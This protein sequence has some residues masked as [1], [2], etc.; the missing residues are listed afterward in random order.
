MLSILI[1]LIGSIEFGINTGGDYPIDLIEEFLDGG[2]FTSVF[3]HSVSGVLNPYHGMYLWSVSDERIGSLSNL[4]NN[5]TP[6]KIY[7]EAGYTPRWMSGWNTTTGMINHIPETIDW[8]ADLVS[9]VVNRYKTGGVLGLSNGITGIGLWNEPD[10]C[11][12]MGGIGDPPDVFLG[13]IKYGES[14][15]LAATAASEADPNIEVVTGGFLSPAHTELGYDWEMN[16]EARLQPVFTHEY[17]YWWQQGDVVPFAIAWATMPSSLHWHPYFEHTK[18]P[19][20]WVYREWYDPLVLDQGDPMYSTRP[21]ELPELLNDL[22]L[23]QSFPPFD[24]TEISQFAMEYCPTF[25]YNDYPLYPSSEQIYTKWR[26]NYFLTVNLMLLQSNHMDMI[27]PYPASADKWWVPTE[28]SWYNVNY[29]GSGLEYWADYGYRHQS[30]L[31]GGLTCMNFDDSR[32]VPQGKIC[33]WKYSSGSSQSEEVLAL[34][35]TR[36]ILLSNFDYNQNHT[37]RLPLPPGVVDV[38]QTNLRGEPVI[39]P[40]IIGNGSV[41][42]QVNGYIS[43]LEYIYTNQQES[44]HPIESVQPIWSRAGNSITVTVPSTFNR[45]F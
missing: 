36:E 44:A 12:H 33:I 7:L 17:P 1:F 31:L 2:N 13:M 30:S 18:E 41:T 27:A 11:G 28:N 19:M 38:Q 24:W 4:T 26:A 20:G 40:V 21:E 39:T 15:A 42:V 6:V 3:E 34:R 16:T 43:Y 8:Y 35:T 5:G 14:A 37:V 9:A 25:T 45:Q 10:G 32:S 22:F 23:S 29:T